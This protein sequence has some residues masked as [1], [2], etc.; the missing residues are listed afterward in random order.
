[1]IVEEVPEV[2]LGYSHFIYEHIHFEILTKAA[3][4]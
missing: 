1:M 4:F 3:L 2:P